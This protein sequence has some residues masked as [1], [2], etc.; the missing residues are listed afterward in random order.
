M[1]KFICL[2]ASVSAINLA[3]SDVPHDYGD[4]AKIEA[5][6]KTTMDSAADMEAKRT[7]AVSAQAASDVWR[8]QG[9]KTAWA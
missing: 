5:Q 7:G 2:I 9:A 3:P 6:H 8:A 1:F 4:P